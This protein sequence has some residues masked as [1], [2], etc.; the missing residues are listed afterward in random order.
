MIADSIRGDRLMR[1]HRALYGLEMDP[2]ALDRARSRF[3]QPP[4]SY[5]SHQS[6]TTTRSASP[7]PSI[8]EQQRRKRED[9]RF[10][11]RGKLMD[12]RAAS[13]P[14]EQFLVQVKEET[15]R[16][17]HAN[18]RNN[19]VSERYIPSEGEEESEAIETIKKRWVEQGIWKD[20]WNEMAAGRYMYVGRRWKHEDQLE[21]ES[22][23][24]TDTEAEPSPLR[25]LFVIQ[26]PQSRPRRS[27]SDDEMRRI[28]ERRVVR[29]R[30]RE[31]SRPY[32]QF[33]YQISK[34]R[35]RVKQEVS[36]G[37][38]DEADAVDINTEAYKNVKNIWTRRGIWNEG[39]G[40]L[41]GMSWKH[42]SPLEEE[43][44]S[45]DP[46]PIPA[47]RL[48]N[49]NHNAG[50]LF[51]E[52]LF[53]IPGSPIPVASSQRQ[54]SVTQ[55]RSQQEPS[56]NVG[57]AGLDNVNVDCSSAESI[58][59]RSRAGKKVLHPPTGNPS[60]PRRKKPSS[61]IAQP[62]TNASLGT[63][64]STKV[65]KATRNK[66]SGPQQI[67]KVSQ[68]V[69]SGDP[70]V[71]DVPLPQT[72]D[73]PPRRSRL[74]QG[75]TPEIPSLKV[76]GRPRA[77]RIISG[78]PASI[79]SAKPQGISKKHRVRTTRGKV[80]KVTIRLCSNFSLEG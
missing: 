62:V 30:E 29:E 69:L 52:H 6:G 5:K 76:I 31:A 15:R 8:N 75:D 33:I 16:I 18:P 71:N 66:K 9:E 49:N 60:R 7:E 58:P 27:K 70:E 57:S 23:S 42:E 54:I 80:R 50:G 56:S 59:P 45:E 39:W 78:N 2:L 36:N 32:H 64:H 79:D 55:S 21:L 67:P 48:A 11:R 41:P 51:T 19:G 38:K 44:P 26:K 40:I 24:E 20:E 74:L 25:S 65:M 14:L 43:E 53:G 34:E 17:W 61:E 72:I 35:E 73:T 13:F 22:E 37:D 12:D 28:T 46:A 4:P 68:K 77:K 10:H 1:A 47:N 63:V 3:S